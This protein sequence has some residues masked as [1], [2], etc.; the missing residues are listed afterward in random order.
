[1]TLEFN[2]DLGRQIVPI[3]V[4]ILDN[5]ILDVPVSRLQHRAQQVA[6]DRMVVAPHS[7]S[8]QGHNPRADHGHGDLPSLTYHNTSSALAQKT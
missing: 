2:R 3:V 5:F 8:A 4:K 7:N 1:M 6:P